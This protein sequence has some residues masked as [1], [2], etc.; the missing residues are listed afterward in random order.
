MKMKKK[1][2]TLSEYKRLCSLAMLDE[3][4]PESEI[5]IRNLNSF[6]SY[7][8]RIQLSDIS[9]GSDTSRYG[10]KV[11][12]FRNDITDKSLSMYDIVKN[13]PCVSGAFFSVPRVIP[14]NDKD[15]GDE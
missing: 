13:A 15:P 7:A 9:K 5:I 11:N 1:Y 4:E 12:R 10:N 6:F 2:V 3:S 14:I 8:E